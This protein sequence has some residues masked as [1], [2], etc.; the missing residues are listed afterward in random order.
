MIP[1]L[2]VIFRVCRMHAAGLAHWCEMPQ[3]Y[4]TLYKEPLKSFGQKIAPC[5]KNVVEG[6]SMAQTRGVI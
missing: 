4:N 2:S 1:P 5:G 6:G 3:D